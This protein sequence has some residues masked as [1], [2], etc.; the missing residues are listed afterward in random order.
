VTAELGSQ[1]TKTSGGEGVKG[2][3]GERRVRRRKVRIE[4]GEREGKEKRG[5][6]QV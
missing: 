1:D 3:L 5:R 2:D 6:I 4:K